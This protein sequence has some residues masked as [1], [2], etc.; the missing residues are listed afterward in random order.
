[1]EGNNKEIDMRFEVCREG[2]VVA[3][4]KKCNQKVYME[5]RAFFQNVYDNNFCM[6]V[7]VVG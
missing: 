6:T 1:L 2:Y 3:N 4:G 5:L 7:I